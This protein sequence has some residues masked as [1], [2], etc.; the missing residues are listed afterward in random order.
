MKHLS[1]DADAI[2]R[3]SNESLKNNWGYV[4]L[5]R[6]E[7][8]DMFRKLKPIADPQAIWFV[9]H[10]GTPVGF[11]L[12]FPDLNVILRRI[13]G[14]LFPFGFLQ[15]LFGVKK[16]EDY[17]LFGLAVLPAY[18]GKGLDVL[19]YTQ[20]FNALSPRIRRLE[21]NYILEDNA[22]I[23]NALEKLG[24]DLVKKYRV[25]EKGIAAIAP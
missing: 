3:I 4:P 2:F 5:N 14:K 6:D 23:R 24:L 15:L 22:K 18:H 25:Y 19:L 11:A 1:R 12:G 9:E 16:V 7:L 20:L 10:N 17:R 21:A 13:G 8:Q